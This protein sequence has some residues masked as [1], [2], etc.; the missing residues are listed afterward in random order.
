MQVKGKQCILPF[1]MSD[2]AERRNHL[3]FLRKCRLY[4]YKTEALFG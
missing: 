3:L 2:R 4:F 1:F